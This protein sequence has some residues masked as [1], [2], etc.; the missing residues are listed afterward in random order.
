[1][2]FNHYFHNEELI[3]TAGAS[4][5]LGQLYSVKSWHLRLT[6]NPPHGEVYLFIRNICSYEIFSRHYNQKTGLM[7]WHIL[8]DNTLEHKAKKVMLV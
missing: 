4:L 6:P 1:M 2:D 3:Y 5:T 7:Q 8:I